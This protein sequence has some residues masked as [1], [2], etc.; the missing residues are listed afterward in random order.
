[1]HDLVAE[2]RRKE[3]VAVLAVFAFC[4]ARIGKAALVLRH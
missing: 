2:E 1:M 3:G 4:C